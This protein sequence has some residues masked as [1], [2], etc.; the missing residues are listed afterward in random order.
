VSVIPL[1]VIFFVRKPDGRIRASPTSPFITRETT[2][3]LSSPYSAAQID[4]GF[5]IPLIVNKTLVLVL[6]ACSLDVAQRQL[7]GS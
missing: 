1:K 6:L 4:K 3:D 7:L 2:T 5:V